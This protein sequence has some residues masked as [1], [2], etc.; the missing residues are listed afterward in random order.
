MPLIQKASLLPSMNRF[1]SSIND[2]LC[3]TLYL[4]C[5]LKSFELGLRH[6]ACHCVSDCKMNFFNLIFIKKLHYN[7]RYDISFIITSI[8]LISDGILWSESLLFYTA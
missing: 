4:L 3:F 5:D 8:A 1:A 7:L 2:T 6:N